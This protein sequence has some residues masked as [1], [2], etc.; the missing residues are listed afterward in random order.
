MRR[1]CRSSWLGLVALIAACGRTGLYADDPDAGAWFTDAAEDEPPPRDA[2]WD[3]PREAP[4]DVLGCAPEPEAC[5]GVDDDCNGLIDDGLASEPCEGGGRSYCVAG[6]M[7]QCPR[8]CEACVPGSTRVC[9]L[10]YCRYWGTET[11]A[12][13]G[14]SFSYCRE[15]S[16]PPACKQTAKEHQASAAL[17]Q[18]CVDAGYCCRDSYDL[19]HDGNRAEML[20]QCEDVACGP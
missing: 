1:H 7:S 14:R 20:G 8:R 16:P 15:G 18:C 17:E 13:D 2:A 19:D 4:P 9:F 3:A 10:S 11:C 6:R 5:N 12:A